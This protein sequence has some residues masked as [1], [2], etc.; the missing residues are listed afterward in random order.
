MRDDRVVGLAAG[1]TA[2]TL[3]LVALFALSVPA[4]HASKSAPRPAVRAGLDELGLPVSWY[5][6]WWSTVLVAFALVCFAVAALIV[7]RRPRDRVAWFAALLVVAL[8]AANA[9]NMEALVEQRPALEGAATVA[10]QLLLTCL[11]LFLFTFPDG[12][13]HPRWSSVLVAASLVALVVARGSVA[14]PVSE[15]LFW[16]LL[17]GLG[18]GL[19]AQVHRYRRVSTPEQR[20]QTRWVTLALAV[21]VV[22]QLVFPLL[23]SVPALSRPGA[24]AA[25]LDMASPAG[26][27]AGFALVPLALAVAL[28]RKGLWGLDVVVNRALV[29]GGLTISLLALYVGVAAGLGRSLG[30]P[31]NAGGSLFGAALVALAFAPLRE[32]IQRGVN[33]LMYGQRDEPYQVLSALG[34]RL[35][36]T[37]A[38][39]SVLQTVVDSVSVALKSPYVALAL[40]RDG[41]L[42]VA[43]QRGSDVPDL[44]VLPLVHRRQAVGELRVAPRSPAEAFS[45][46]DRALLDDLARHAGAAVHAVHLTEELQQSRE[47]LVTAR[48][49]ERRRLRRDLHDGLG[50]ALA[51]MTLQAET[52]RELLTEQPD[53]ATSILSDLVVQL[54]SSTADIRRLVYDLR[55]PALDDLGLIGALRTFLTRSRSSQVDLHLDLPDDLPPLSAAAEVAIYRI[56]Q[57]AVVNVLRH[58]GATTCTVRLRAEEGGVVVEVDDD[59]VG[60]RGDVSEGVG[61]RSMRERAAELG[62]T[63]SVT[64]AAGRGTGVRV[65]LPRTS[66]VEMAG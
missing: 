17:L 21:A 48:E 10:F 9:P 11:V 33:R 2:L 39:Y 3:P 43:A 6:A 61:L 52:A 13:F 8:G 15:A 58:A 22:T 65:R 34:Q 18:T 24:G 49:E 30:A 66:P 54:Q 55:P 40:Q 56:V 41:I 53:V 1:W 50:P 59:G 62:G 42:Q 29:Y 14:T 25:L 47:R 27:S 4:V 46:A 31:G 20:Q 16:A 51:S 37:G 32:R 12:R 26:I 5:A 64:G 38:P 19:A 57:E 60:L 7:A 35:Q 28:L 63:C 23:E 44:L 45:P 36:A